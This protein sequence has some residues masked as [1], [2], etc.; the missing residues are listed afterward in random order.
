M[1]SLSLKKSQESTKYHMIPTRKLILKRL[2][3][4]S[5]GKGLEHIGALTDMF[6]YRA[7]LGKCLT[8]FFYKIKYIL[9]QGYNSKYMQKKQKHMSAERLVH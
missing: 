6:K 9:T 1:T 7:P 4:A 8:I 3:T 5:T 2:P